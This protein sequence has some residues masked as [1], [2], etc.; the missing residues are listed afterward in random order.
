MSTPEPYDRISVEEI[1]QINKA[2]EATQGDALSAAEVLG[3][4][5]NRINNAISRNPALTARWRTSQTM[6]DGE[7][8]INP[9]TAINRTPPKPLGLSPAQRQAIELS[10]G[11]RKINKSLA[12]L[13][14]K[15]AEIQAISSIEEFAGQHFQETLSIMHGGLLKS[16]MRLMILAERIESQYLQD[17]NMEEKDR[18]WWWDQYFRILE[19][20]RDMNDQ[21]NKAAL[22]KALIEIKKKE[23]GGLGKPGFSPHTTTAIQINVPANSEVK[24]NTPNVVDSG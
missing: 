19:K 22:T 9:T 3:V 20:L 5:V 23:G 18:K 12:K 10:I 16:A 8:N 21:T 24:T 2:M 4:S 6:L 13:G 15:S 7:T 11:E 17:E 1:A 14:F